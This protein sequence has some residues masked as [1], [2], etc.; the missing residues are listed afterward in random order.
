[1]YVCTYMC[2][3]ACVLSR[4]HVSGSN[5]LEGILNTVERQDDVPKHYFRHYLTIVKKI[6][7]SAPLICGT[8]YVIC[9]GSQQRE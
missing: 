3:C 4:E 9:T 5:H 8:E 7:S 2:V 1:M 6:H